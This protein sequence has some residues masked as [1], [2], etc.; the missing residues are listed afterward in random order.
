MTFGKVGVVGLGLIGGS[1]SSA[2]MKSGEVGEVFGVERNAEAL[3]FALEKGIV[4]DGSTEIGEGLSACEVVVIATYVDS[5]ASV[6]SDLSRFVSQ[7]SVVCDTGSVKAPIV[8]KI[9]KGPLA[10]SFVGAHPVAGTEKS[11]TR[12][13]DPS[14][15][16]GKTCVLTPVESTSPHALERAGKLWKIAGCSIAEMDPETHDEI[17]SLVSHLPHF[18][19]YSLLSTVASVDGGLFDFSG[20]SLADFTRVCESS[21]GM[22]AGIF[23]ENRDAILR[24]VRR[25]TDESREIEKAI[26][27]GNV[28]LLEARLGKLAAVKRGMPKGSRD[29]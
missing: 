22:W 8:R 28:E 29:V 10:G 25:F 11:G 5:V 2:L 17:F 26:K 27:S 24:A 21:P 15:F 4:N 13:S 12:F 18:I 16:S 19:A 14:L 9:E 3:R 6:A 23:S 1:L 20:G 7:G